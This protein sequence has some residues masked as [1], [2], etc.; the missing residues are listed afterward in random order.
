MGNHVVQYF[1][2]YRKTAAKAFQISIKIY[3]LLKSEP[4]SANTEFT[5]YKAFTMPTMTYVCPACEFVADSHL[6]KLQPLQNKALR[7]TVNLK[8]STMTG[9]LHVEFKIPYIYDFVTKLCRQQTEI[10]QNH[11]NI[12]V[13]NIGQS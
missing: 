10:I 6:L 9:D 3:S 11:E 7:T 8:R 12:N 5:L 2:I 13:L 1:N 4:L